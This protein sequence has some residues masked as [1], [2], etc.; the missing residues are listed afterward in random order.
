MTNEDVQRILAHLAGAFPVVSQAIDG[1]EKTRYDTLDD[2]RLM[3]TVHPDFL[4]SELFDRFRGTD[5]VIGHVVDYQGPDLPMVASVGFVTAKP[6][7]LPAILYH[8]TSVNDEQSIRSRGILTGALIGRESRGQ[9]ASS[10]HYICVSATLE[11]ARFWAMRLHSD[12]A[13]LIFPIA[14]EG[15]GLQFVEDPSCSLS[16]GEVNG[17]IVVG[18]VIPPEML[19]DPIQA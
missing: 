11:D 7:T 3:F 1:E 2:P 10:R 4:T 16:G 5:W 9:F 15:L 14:N 18:T 12:K 13:A 17:Y 8:T 6:A 19:G